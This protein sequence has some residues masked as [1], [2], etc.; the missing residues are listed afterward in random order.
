MEGSNETASLHQT[1]TV[2]GLYG[3]KGCGKSFLLNGLRNFLNPQKFLFVEGSEAI[4]AVVEGGFQAFIGMS[5]E[6]RVHARQLAVNSIADR[7]LKEDKVAIVAG[8]FSFWNCL[9]RQPEPVVTDDDMKIYSHILYLDTPEDLTRQ[10]TLDDQVQVRQDIPSNDIKQWKDFEILQ[11]RKLCYQHQI[12]FALLESDT[13]AAHISAIIEGLLQNEE[14][15]LANARKKLDNILRETGLS[16]PTKMMVFDADKTI[17]PEDTGALFWNI[18]KPALGLEQVPMTKIYSGWGYEYSAFQQVSLFYEEAANREDLQEICRHVAGVVKIYPQMMNLLRL[19]C[20]SRNVA[21]VIVTCGLS[22]IWEMILERMGIW[23]KVAV[24]GLEEMSRGFVVTPQV[25]E[26]LVARLQTGYKMCVWAFGDSPVDMGMLRKAD[27]AVVIV[28]D[29]L[30]RSKSMESELRSNVEL[31]GFKGYQAVLSDGASPRLTPDILP[32]LD[33][34]SQEFLTSI[35]G[36]LPEVTLNVFELTKS[37]AASALATATRDCNVYGPALWEAHRKVGRHLATDTLAT[38]LGL[39]DYSIPHV[40]GNQTKGYQLAGQESTLIIGILRAGL[41]LAEGL[42]EHLPRS[43][44]YLAHESHEVDFKHLEG[45][46]TV[47]LVDF[48]INSGK[49]IIE[50]IRRIRSLD[51]SI[52]IVVVAGVVQSDFIARYMNVGIAPISQEACRDMT[53]ALCQETRRIVDLVT[54][55]VSENKFKG[56]G[57]TDTGNRLFNTTRLSWD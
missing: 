6:E 13:S 27:S 44:L 1:A 51:A 14:A 46:K 12:L 11:L 21:A 2:I 9:K 5:A 39:E 45:K 8:H 10:R 38:V 36:R 31:Q 54:L 52:R 37:A 28:G 30:T 35:F 55:R 18:V 40:Q 23:G 7:C 56:V 57:G 17:T 32:L 25:K 29:Q 20:E 22:R 4:A 33:L 42:F 19:T 26:E 47:M 24:I 49:T 48:V 15:N 43:M 50:F 3:V 41:P 53:P 34:G 16:R